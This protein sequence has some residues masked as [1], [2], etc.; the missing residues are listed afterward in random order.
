MQILEP[1]RP[2]IDRE[3]CGRNNQRVKTAHIAK[4]NDPT[5]EARKLWIYSQCYP[6]IGLVVAVVGS[7]AGCSLGI[8]GFGSEDISDGCATKDIGK[9][10][11]SESH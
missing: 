6:W 4:N 5:I 10:D 3:I 2:N 7:F 8:F 9:G 11:T 1:S